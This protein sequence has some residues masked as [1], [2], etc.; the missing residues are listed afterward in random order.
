VAP[1][2]PSAPWL[3]PTQPTPRFARDKESSSSCQPLGNPWSVSS[4]R[5]SPST[6]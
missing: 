2:K 1:L 6:C 5:P 3:F 4:S